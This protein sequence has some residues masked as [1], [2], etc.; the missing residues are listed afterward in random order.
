MLQGTPCQSVTPSPNADVRYRNAAN[1]AGTLSVRHAPPS[2]VCG[3][4]LIR[5]SR[6]SLRDVLLGVWADLSV[7]CAVMF[8]DHVPCCI[9]IGILKN[10]KFTLWIV[11]ELGYGLRIV[12][13]STDERCTTCTEYCGLHGL[14]VFTCCL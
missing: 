4:L 9:L 2:V 6:L 13:C 3:I 7:Y 1:A 12:S 11:S 8:I 10:I 5:L 14:G